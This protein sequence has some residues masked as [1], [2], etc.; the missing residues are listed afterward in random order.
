MIAWWILPLAISVSCLLTI[1]WWCDE[2]MP[3][4]SLMAAVAVFL[5]IVPNAI[6][7]VFAFLISR[8]MP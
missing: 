1:A 6:V 4:R 2:N 7:W 3:Y 5:A 8:M